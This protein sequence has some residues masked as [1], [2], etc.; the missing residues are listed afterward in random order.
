MTHWT[1]K[2]KLSFGIHAGVVSIPFGFSTV[3]AFLFWRSL[4]GSGWIAAP[5]VGVVDVLALLGLVLYIVGIESPFVWLRHLLPFI[6]IVPLGIELY[7]LLQHNGPLTAGAVTVLVSALLVLI[8]WKCF[9]TIER[10]FI[11][12]I[13]AAREKAREQLGTFQRTFA[14]LEEM[15]GIADTFAL[16]RMRYHAPVASARIAE[17]VDYPAPKKSRIHA[18]LEATHAGADADAQ[19][20]PKCGAHIADRSAWLAARRWKRCNNCKEN[21]A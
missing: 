14:Q 11:D 7:T 12:P 13:E 21:V 20:C 10:L 3:S 2:R 9:T 8:A 6:S 17:Q 5:M 18:Q 1:I 15:N 19:S 4:F 16:E